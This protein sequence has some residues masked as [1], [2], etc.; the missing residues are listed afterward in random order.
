MAIVNGSKVRDD[1]AGYS[2][3]FLAGVARDFGSGYDVVLLANREKL[4]T[5]VRLTFTSAEVGNGVA[6]DG[7]TLANQDGGL[8]VRVQGEDASGTLTGPVG[9]FDDEGISFVAD[10]SYTFDVR[11]LVSGVERGTQFGVVRLGTSADDYYAE[12]GST[13]AAYI[14]GGRGNDDIN[15]GL[16]DDFLVGG[17]GNDTLFGGRAGD[18]SFIGGVGNDTIDGGAGSDLA[19]FNISTDGSDTVDLGIGNDRVNV[20]ASATTNLIRLT[21]TSAEV[22]NGIVT[23]AG[24][25][26][27][28]DGGLAVRM[29]TSDDGDLGTASR[30]D[31]EGIT[32]FSST[33]GRLTFEVRD[34]VSNAVRGDQFAAVQLGTA[35]GEAINNSAAV[36]S[37]YVNG[38]AGNDTITGGSADDF[39]VGGTGADRLIGGNGDDSFIGGVGNDTISG[40]LGNDTVIMNVITD[41]ADSVNL[42]VGADRVILNTTDGNENIRLFFNSTEVGNGD[43]N[44]GDK[45]P[46]LAVGVQAF[47]EEGE[48]SFPTSRFDDEGISFIA[49]EGVMLSVRDN[50]NFLYLPTEDMSEVRLGTN[51]SDTFDTS[52]ATG[53]VYINAGAGDDSFIGS[54]GRDTFLGGAGNDLINPGTSG[55]YF[56]GGAGNDT[57]VFD[58]FASSSYIVDFDSGSDKIDLSAFNI[59]YNDVSVDYSGDGSYFV[60]VYIED[61]EGSYRIDA[62]VIT[63]G[64]DMPIE[65][66]FIF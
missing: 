46:V 64:G 44:S 56:S 17:A 57:Y 24:T 19:I 59:S 3:A 22:G 33:P 35:A 27:N 12:G 5:Q 60:R 62:A 6:T 25:L 29:Q 26:A 11:D 2:L 48:P 14:N 40:G 58:E 41:G 63:P 7:G 43:V 36:V 49:G 61:S 45:T 37:Y 1:T 10:G 23:D 50:T 18:D 13:V 38:G 51:R 8:A 20:T 53:T 28:Q 31:D 9:R 21:F 16:G 54:F 4:Y 15:G 30:F 52:N 39:L 55:G 32:F 66:D 42:G 34:L 65:S 47:S